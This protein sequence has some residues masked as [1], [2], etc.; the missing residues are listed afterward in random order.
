M[1]LEVS[2]CNEAFASIFEPFDI[3]CLTFESQVNT[4]RGEAH[5][6]YPEMRSTYLRHL[7]YLCRETPVV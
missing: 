6:S 5:P 4:R 7:D 1:K 3:P 2:R